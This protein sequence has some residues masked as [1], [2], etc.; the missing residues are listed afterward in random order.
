MKIILT[1]SLGHIS[2][3][4]TEE[5]V[6]KGHAVTVISSNSEKQKEIEL[7]AEINNLSYYHFPGPLLFSRCI[8]LNCD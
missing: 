6:K 3:P 4:L 7:L 5:L 8:N 2:K 1:G